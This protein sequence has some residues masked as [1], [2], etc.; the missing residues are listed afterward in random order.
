MKKTNKEEKTIYIFNKAINT[1]DDLIKID[2]NSIISNEIKEKKWSLNILA[3]EKEKYNL[4]VSYDVIE[5]EGGK[6]ENNENTESESASYAGKVILWILIIIVLAGL[7]YAG[8][9]FLYKK[10]I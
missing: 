4:V 3:E 8:Y 7:G 5:W 9:Y 1:Q 6:G 2:L 10:K